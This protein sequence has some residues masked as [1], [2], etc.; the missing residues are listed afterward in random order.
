MKSAQGLCIAEQAH[1]GGA[2][3]LRFAP[4]ARAGP[5]GALTQEQWMTRAVFNYGAGPSMLP[6]PVME[7]MQ[8][9]LRDYQGRGM[10]IM[11]MNHRDDAFQEIL[12]AAKA[13]FR[14]LM[15]I[16]D[17]YKVIWSHG[18]G[19][20]QFSSVAMNLLG[21]HPERKALYTNT[22]F[23]ATRAIDEARRFGKVAVVSSSEET[24]FDHIPALEPAL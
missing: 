4:G 18:G 16:P 20:M 9:E 17:D 22:G 1:A 5:W 24:G 6:T 10:S 11:E 14:E 3:G 23:F 2:V 21:R 13:L 8:A 7:Q 19:A 15:E 12:A